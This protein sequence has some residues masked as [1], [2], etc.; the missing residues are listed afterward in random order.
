MVVTNADGMV[1]FCDQTDNY[2]VR[3]TPDTV[4]EALAEACRWES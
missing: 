3:P 2:R 1:V 4:L